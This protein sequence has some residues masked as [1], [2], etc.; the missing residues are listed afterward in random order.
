MRLKLIACKAICRELSYLCAISPNNIDI[1]FLRQEN[2]NSPDLLRK[3]L[4]DEIDVVETGKDNHTNGMRHAGDDFDA[5]L[6]GYGLCAN[7]I[8]NISSKKYKLV[9]PRAHDCITFLLGSK[10]KYSDYFKNMP[11]AYWYTMSWIES[12]ATPGEG[13]YYRSDAEAQYYRDK[14][15]DEE[16]IEYLLEESSSWIKNYKTAAYVKM[17][18]F[19]KEEYMDYTKKAAEAFNWEYRQIDGDMSLMRDFVDGRWDDERFLIV[20]PNNKVVPSHNE[21]IIEFAG[22]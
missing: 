3:V 9:I 8:A 15:F 13:S 20:P 14:G 4:Q 5:I 10:E 17:P 2:H 21:N 18:F 7:G 12:G 19:D 22:G 16:E 6:I 1:S 11:G